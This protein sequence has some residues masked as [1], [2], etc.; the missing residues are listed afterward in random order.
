LIKVGA[1]DAFGKR[2]II[3][4]EID[5]IR[6][7]VGKSTSE[8][9]SNQGGLFDSLIEEEVS[10]VDKWESTKTEFS[11]RELMEMERELLGIYLR[12]HPSQKILKKAKNEWTTNIADIDEKKGLKATIA[13][14]IKTART[15]VT[16]TKQQEMAFLL[17]ADEGGEIEAVVFPKTYA[18]VK[19]MLIPNS[20]VMVKGKVEER[21]DRLSLIVDSI[22][23]VTDSSDSADSTD[24]PNSRPSDPNTII[25]PQGTSKAT[26]FELNKL[27]Q[28]NRGVDQVTLIF[29]N[30]HSNRE[31]KL[32]FGINLT[33]SLKSKISTL[34]H[35]E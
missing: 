21:E 10:I 34:L 35:L 16:K 25:I 11:S 6:L 30:G 29:Q 3:L 19:S 13:A 31:L 15:V 12:E 20:V 8:K 24:L 27:L 1:F 7:K 4:D 22:T 14:I 9:N 2:A 23:P 18:E 28:E 32:P 5:R 26:L 17:L 33:D